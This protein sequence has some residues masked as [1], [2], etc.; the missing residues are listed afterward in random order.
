MKWFLIFG[1]IGFIQLLL[2][3]L[4]TQVIVNKSNKR[5]ALTGF[6]GS[7]KPAVLAAYI[8]AGF[9]FFGE[10]EAS[11]IAAPNEPF[12]T[13]L[14]TGVPL[15]LF[16]M[17]FFLAIPVIIYVAIQSDEQGSAQPTASVNKAKQTKKNV[18]SRKPKSK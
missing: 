10:G 5:P 9:I 2:M 8:Y 3:T 1:T 12:L 13:T 11:T 7:I 14:K 16:S 4:I 18:R 6:R 17:A 15:Y